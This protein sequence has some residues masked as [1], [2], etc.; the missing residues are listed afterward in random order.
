MN[1]TLIWFLI[2]LA[3]LVGE[4]A[5]PGFIIAFFGLGAWV[6][7]GTTAAGW[8]T[9]LEYQL[10]TFLICSLALLFSLRK[11]CKSWFVGDSVNG[12]ASVDDEFIGHQVSVVESIPGGAELGK[13]EIKGAKW[14]ARSD[15]KIDVGK[16]AEII[17]RDGLTLTVK[18]L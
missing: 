2:G 1:D 4:F 7:W 12:D 14:N 10:I 11:L 17:N 18:A 8:T 13:V 9:T 6:T 15:Q 3:F 5:L 16:P